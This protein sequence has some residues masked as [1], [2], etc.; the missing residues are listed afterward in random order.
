MQSLLLK[1]TDQHPDVIAQKKLIDYLKAHPDDGDPGTA[2]TSAK[3][4]GQANPGLNNPG[5]NNPGL[6]N[7][8]QSNSGQSQNVTGDTAGGTTTPRRSVP[9]PVYDQLKIKLI[10]AD[11]LVASL[12]RQHD[13]AL[14]AQ[15]R[16][17]K[18]SREQP[19]LFA[20]YQNMDRDYNVLR[21]NYEELLGR[22]QSANIAQAADTQADKVKLQ[23]IDPPEVPRIP[24]AP[25]R[26]LL[27]T[28]VLLGG[29]AI[30][31]GVTVLF[32]QLDR[33]FASVDDLRALGLP[34]LGGIS[35]LGMAPLRQRMMTALRFSAAV[36]VLMAVYGIVMVHILRSAA[37]I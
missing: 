22:L 6:N 24:A 19:G 26:P 32:G 12:T 4:P 34:V 18:I 21:K 33:S 35:V 16:L 20:E 9:N 25:N 28:G 23:I 10:E 5:L 36:T 14:Q 27:V 37:L 7:P 13:E 30:G 11:T 8:G 2:A 31:L 3:T 15:D 1:Y 29:V 17:E